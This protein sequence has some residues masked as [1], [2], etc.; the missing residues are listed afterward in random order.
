MFYRQTAMQY[1]KRTTALRNLNSF[2][3]NES[4]G[5]MC[6][7][8]TPGNVATPAQLRSACQALPELD[9][10][11]LTGKMNVVPSMSWQAP[12]AAEFLQRGGQENR[13]D[14]YYRYNCAEWR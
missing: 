5:E 9:T 8:T 11:I 2:D 3:F 14:R 1:L 12:V 7:A 10:I 4:L 13:I 6:S